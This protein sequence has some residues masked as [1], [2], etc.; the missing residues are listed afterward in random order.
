MTNKT[1]PPPRETLQDELNSVAIA[2]TLNAHR[3]RRLRLEAIKPKPIE[4]VS[5]RRVREDPALRFAWQI[6]AIAIEAAE[7]P[8][9][10]IPE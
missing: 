10:P 8:M 5:S 1:P 6:T 2:P 7:Q 9:A 3:K 4:V